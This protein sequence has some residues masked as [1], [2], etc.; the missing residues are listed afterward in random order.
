[1]A[2]FRNRLVHLYWELDSESVCSIV[3][4]HLND[5]KEFEKKVVSF[6]QENPLQGP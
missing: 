6:C 5:V 4:D 3:Q 1:M 2:K